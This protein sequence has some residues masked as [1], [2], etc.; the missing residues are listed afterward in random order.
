M[1]VYTELANYIDTISVINTHCHKLPQEK[2]FPQGLKE[3]VEH[4]YLGWCH[5]EW[6]GSK[7]AAE[8]F[9]K[10]LKHNTYFRWIEKSLQKLLQTDQ[11]LNVNTYQ[12]FDEKIKE[13]SASL[14]CDDTFLREVCHYDKIVL[15]GY[16]NPGTNL[17]NPDLYTPTFRINMFLFGYQKDVIDDNGNNPFLV[18]GWPEDMDFDTYLLKIEEKIVEKTKAGCV[19]LKSSLPYDRSIHFVERSYEEAKKGYHNPNA[20][21]EDIVAFQDYIYYYIC[22]IAAKYDIPFQN[23]TGLGNLEGSN[24]MLLREAIAKNPKTRFI[25][26]HGSFPWTDDAL[27]LIHNYANVFADICWMPSLSTTTAVYFLKQLIETGKSDCI[28]WGC[29][30][31]TVIE[32]YASYLAGRHVVAKALAELAEDDFITLEEGKELAEAIFRNNA[33]RIYGV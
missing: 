10:G 29:D 25:L 5:R 26:F 20:T 7:E 18:Y 14:K 11:R 24:A 16:W 21:R 3:L 13:F 32:S 2:G 22:R 27:A 33:K 1:S 12:W 9:F 23:H 15:D 4:T 8:H 17:G 30:S 6:D 19:S 31:W 28:T